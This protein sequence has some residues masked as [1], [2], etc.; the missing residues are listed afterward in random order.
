T[1]AARRMNPTCEIYLLKEPSKV[2]H[3]CGSMPNGS[4]PRALTPISPGS[5]L[6]DNPTGRPPNRLARV[7]KRDGDIDLRIV[8]WRPD[9]ADLRVY[10]QLA[11]HSYVQPSPSVCRVP[12]AGVRAAPDPAATQTTQ[13]LLG[14][15][16][17][18]L[19]I[20]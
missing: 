15:T 14:E 18:L 13:L 12:V 6:A 1:C 5:P 11:A 4:Q 8:A 17:H 3:S 16:F 20:G 9:L 7:N 19:E 2:R 10:G